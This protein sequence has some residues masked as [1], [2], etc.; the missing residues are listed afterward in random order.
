M[1]VFD[2]RATV[3][4]AWAL[5][6]ARLGLQIELAQI[7]RGRILEGMN[8]QHGI[9]N[10]RYFS[11]TMAFQGNALPQDRDALW[12]GLTLWC[13][14]R[15]IYLGGAPEHAF[16]LSTRQTAGMGRLKPWLRGQRV[17]SGWEVREAALA[18]APEPPPFL[19]PEAHDARLEALSGFQQYLVEQMQSTV[20]ALHVL[21]TAPRRQ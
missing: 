14:R 5:T 8:Q 1:L 19:A 11:L 21:R 16:L 18:P 15:G 10:W 9:P 7:P 4:P 6:T 3:T 13:Q 2:R 12:E 20:L 17:L